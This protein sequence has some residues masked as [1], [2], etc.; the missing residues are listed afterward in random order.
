MKGRHYRDK[1][2]SELGLYEYDL[3]IRARDE[4]DQYAMN[5]IPIRLIR[6][7]DMKLVGRNDVRKHFGDPDGPHA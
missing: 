4:F 6:L 7:S 5:K 3:S 2:R 1:L